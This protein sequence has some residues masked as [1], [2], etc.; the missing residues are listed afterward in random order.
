MTEVWYRS[1]GTGEI[2]IR[3]SGGQWVVTEPAG[4][5]KTVCLFPGDEPT[6]TDGGATITVEVQS[7]RIGTDSE[8]NYLTVELKDPDIVSSSQEPNEQYETSTTSVSKDYPE[9]NLTE[10]RG[11][12]EFVTVEAT[13]SEVE[14]VAKNTSNTPDLKAIVREEG[15]SKRVPLVVS[16][17]VSH[18]HFD[19][20]ET[21]RFR[22]VKDHR[23]VKKNENQL[24]VT[25]D[26]DF[27]VV[28]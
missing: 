2:Q 8:T 24:L 11:S 6:P 13:I 18:P 3:R 23:Y 9:R 4:D 19:V 22:G 1:G 12:E 27:T 5:S 20:G 26:T 16:D 7:F 28:E 15:S 21:I 14:F 17:G 10:L 25:D